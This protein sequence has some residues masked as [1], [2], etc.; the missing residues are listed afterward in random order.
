MRVT[1]RQLRYFK[2]V[3]E[4]G[5]FARA[6]ESVFISQP[7]LS[8]QVRELE[9]TLGWP[10]FKRD[11]HGVALTALG[12][13][14][15]AQALRVLDEALLLETMGKRFNEGPFPSPWASSQPWRPT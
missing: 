7:A 5:S 14:V 10:L 11:S 15:H 9:T 6:A 4:N 3:V 1:L 8:L 12:R 13:E 2:A